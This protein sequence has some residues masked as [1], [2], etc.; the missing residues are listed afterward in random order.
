[1]SR[2][3]RFRAEWVAR[4]VARYLDLKPRRDRALKEAMKGCR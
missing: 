2:D 4:V 3:E 1:M